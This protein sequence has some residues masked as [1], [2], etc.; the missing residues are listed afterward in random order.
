MMED[1]RFQEIFAAYADGLLAVSYTYVKDWSIAED[2]VQD[3][4]IKFWQTSSQFNGES[5]LKTYL[6]RMAI[7]RSKD[8][9]KSWRYRTHQLTTHFFIKQAVPDRIVKNEE[10]S[11]LA[12]VIFQLP[13]KYREVVILYFYKEL[14]YKEIAHL[15]ETPESTVKNRMYKAKEL[16]KGNLPNERWEVLF[17]E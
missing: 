15:L 11:M 12:E 7:N 13:V 1:E 3:V 5:E 16:L 2:I 10:Q 14:T 8:Y 6:T 17:D 9:L 4:F